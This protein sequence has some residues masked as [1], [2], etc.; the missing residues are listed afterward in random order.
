MATEATK[1]LDLAT[2]PTGA[3]PIPAARLEL[4]PHLPLPSETQ[5]WIPGREAPTHEEIAREAYALYEARGRESGWDV[6]D[7][8]AAEETLR[9]RSIRSTGSMR[10]ES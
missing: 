9:R 7:W 6:E 10:D 2:Q 3:L 8:L 5:A 4:P 1:N